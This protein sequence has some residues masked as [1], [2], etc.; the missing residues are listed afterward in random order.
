MASDNLQ[1]KAFSG[2][3]WGFL[4]KFSL[5]LFGFI[6][7]VI[8]ARLLMPSDFGLINHGDALNFV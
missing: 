8:L 7:G 2:M 5:Q 4:E 1:Q 3:I 6:Q